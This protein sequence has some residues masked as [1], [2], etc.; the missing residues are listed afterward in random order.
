MEAVWR[1]V[2]NVDTAAGDVVVDPVVRR[3]GRL[4]V[5]LDGP[6]CVFSGE[7]E[8]D[9]LERAYTIWIGPG[10]QVL[11]T[12]WGS[13]T[14]VR[15]VVIGEAVDGDIRALF[16]VTARYG[17]QAVDVSGDGIPEI[18]ACDQRDPAKGVILYVH[19]WDSS[20]RTYRLIGEH[21]AD[22]CHCFQL[23]CLSVTRE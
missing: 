20:A 12:E 6:V 18:I 5:Q 15:T 17:V 4:G 16:E 13:G 7:R 22:V 2:F 23:S 9:L 10:A 14:T 21:A 8:Q 19:A 11:V 1:C 3:D